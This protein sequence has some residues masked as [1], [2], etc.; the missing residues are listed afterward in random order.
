MIPPSPG[1]PRVRNCPRNREQMGEKM[2]FREPRFRPRGARDSEITKPLLCQL[3]YGGD[4]MSIADS[5]GYAMFS[6]NVGMLG[7]KRQTV[8]VP[9]DLLCQLGKVSLVRSVTVSFDREEVS[10]C[11][12]DGSCCTANRRCPNP[13]R[14]VCLPRRWASALR[15]VSRTSFNRLPTSSAR[16]R[17][18]K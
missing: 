7:E 13:G 8:V 4:L 11:P 2:R 6:G 1:S 12:A 10:R 17:S 16:N 5:A 15:T 18:T 14:Q 9:F 3:S